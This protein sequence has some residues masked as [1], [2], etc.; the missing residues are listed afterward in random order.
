MLN[1]SGG[2]SNGSARSRSKPSA[3]LSRSAILAA[4][5]AGVL[6]L[7]AATY[8][9]LGDDEGH[10]IRALPAP[11]RQGLYHR[12]M[13]NLKTICDPA[14]GRSMREFCRAQAGL[15]LKFPECDDECHRTAR[16]NLSLPRP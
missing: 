12:T 6:L 14:P 5:T 1:V 9:W 7:I 15:A 2:G 3:Q 10:E 4:A 16:R 11:Q 13:E 8:S